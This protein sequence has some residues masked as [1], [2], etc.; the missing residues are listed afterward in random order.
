MSSLYVY[1]PS[2]Q[3]LEGV[4]LQV[5]VLASGSSLDS[6]NALIYSAAFGQSIG[7]FCLAIVTDAL[8]TSGGKQAS[9][10]SS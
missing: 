1:P 4:P 6:E 10:V 7:L 8:E 2:T 3:R 5:Q 9:R